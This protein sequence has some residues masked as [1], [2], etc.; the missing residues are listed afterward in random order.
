[1]KDAND[2]TVAALKDRLKQLNL[3]TAGSKSELILR[4]NEADPT[5]QWMG[6]DVPG[7][8]TTGGE[9]GARGVT[10]VQD[11]IAN[12]EELQIRASWLGREQDLAKR[13]RELMQ[14]EIEFMRREN[15]QLRA[16][17]Q[18][19]NN[20]GTSTVTTKVG[21]T[22]L[23]EMLPSYDG[24]KGSFQRWKE[25]LLMVKQ[26]Y[27]LDEGMTKLLLGA[28]LTGEA[29]EWFH[30]VSTHLSMTVDELLTDECH[31]RT[32]RKQADIC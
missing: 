2:L 7:E 25:Q 5:G 3:S 22:N 14:R 10:H 9:D 12:E 28:K 11:V 6:Q 29:E 20:L 26:M 27:Q 17:M 30:S 1:M 21:L 18:S 32:T 16:M 4:L 8:V 19:A 23:K 24:K 13:E 31:V 15:E